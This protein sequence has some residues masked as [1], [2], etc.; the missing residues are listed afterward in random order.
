M[1]ATEIQASLITRERESQHLSNRREDDH[2]DGVI[3][4]PL[5]QLQTIILEIFCNKI[6]LVFVGEVS[7]IHAKQWIDNFNGAKDSKLEYI[8]GLTNSLFVVEVINFPGG[9]TRE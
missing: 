6:I 3:R 9:Q 1:R 5:H 8:D 2:D 7:F 4:I